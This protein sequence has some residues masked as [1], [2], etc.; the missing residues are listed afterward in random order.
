MSHQLPLRMALAGAPTFEHFEAGANGAALAALRGPERL[1][2]LWGAPGTGKS[3][4]LQAAC[5]EAANAQASSAYLP[6]HEPALAPAMAA[7]LESIALVCVDDLDAVAGQP[8]WEAA[9]FGLY[10]EVSAG[11]GRLVFAAAAPPQALPLGLADLRSRLSACAVFHLEP[12]DDADKVHAL[13]R[14]GARRGLDV[15]EEVAWFLLRHWRRDL[16]ALCAL[17]DRL[18][19]AS[20][21]AQRRVTIP[22]VR[23]VIAARD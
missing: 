23:G 10:N 13:R 11:G 8:A 12:L 21:A 5:A 9:L 3:H 14:Q 2:Y 22:F 18:D 15:S 6:L 1:I 4:L 20:L 7:G 16:P 19:R 17:L